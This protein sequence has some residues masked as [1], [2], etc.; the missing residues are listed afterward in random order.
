MPP[1]RQQIGESRRQ[2]PPLLLTRD[3]KPF[4]AADIVRGAC[5]FLLLSGPSVHRIADIEKLRQR[6]VMIFGVNNS[7]AIAPCRFW[8]CVDPPEKFHSAIWHDPNCLKIVPDRFLTKK[9]RVKQSDTSFRWSDYVFDC[10]GVIGYRRH[11]NFDPRAWLWQTKVNW[12]CDKKNSRRNRKRAPDAVE[13]HYHVLNVMFPALRLCFYLGF[14]EV[15]LLGCD[16]GMSADQP[17]SFPERK[18]PAASASNNG[19]YL[20]VGHMLESL[21]PHFRE[22][23]F[24]VYNCN[25]QSGLEAFEYL[26][27][28]EA[29]HRATER[30]PE[31]LDTLGWYDKANTHD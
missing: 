12:G 5:G 22:N 29:I 18:N 16:W 23:D 31:Q 28:R 14:R 21:V 27:F 6:G 8:T 15:Y 3:K 25:P 1:T 26:P 17:Y 4:D 13:R 30:T 20:K 24:H 10:P 9:T 7:P 2:H 19:T 11:A